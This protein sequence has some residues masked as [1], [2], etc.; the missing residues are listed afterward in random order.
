VKADPECA[1]CRH[2]RFHRLQWSNNWPANLSRPGMPTAEVRPA[3]ARATDVGGP[4][5][6]PRPAAV[7]FVAD[8]GGDA[9]AIAARGVAVA[10]AKGELHARLDTAEGS[11]L[12]EGR[13]FQKGI[14]G[15]RS[16]VLEPMQYGKLLLAGDAAHDVP[17]TGAKGLN[18]AAG[19][20]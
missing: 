6:L 18:L 13:I 12:K 15:M 7:Q 8:F 14:I 1:E 9:Q 4:R 16:F 20:G 17:P 3:A 2:M 19:D 11:Q 5:H 10:P